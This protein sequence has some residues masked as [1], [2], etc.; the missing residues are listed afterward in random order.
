MRF[1]DLGPLEGPTLFFGGPYGNLQ[2]LLRLRQIAEELRL[3]PERVV[4]TGDVVAYCAQPEETVNAIRAWG[5]PVL[6]G[7]VEQ[8]LAAGRDDCGCNFAPDTTCDVLSRRW[9]AYCRAALSPESLAWMAALPVGLRFEA[10][11]RRIG[12]VHGA[13]SAVAAYVFRSTPWSWKRRELELAGCEVIVAGHCGVP[14]LHAE[15]GRLWANAGVIGIPANEGIPRVW[16][17]L[18]VPLPGGG[19]RASLHPYA[20]DHARAAALME[21]AG[22]PRQYADTLRTGLWDN[23]DILPVAE[24]CARGHPLDFPPVELPPPERP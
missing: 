14:F 19:L 8:Q 7:N 23:C 11:G 24:T 13:Y 2:A 22:L 5:I 21:S 3:P 18:L 17:L 16:Y 1:V 4:C 9:Y 20:F 6:A 15:G 12:V 10:G